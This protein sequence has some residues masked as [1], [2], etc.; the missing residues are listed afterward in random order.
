MTSTLFPFQTE[1][2]DKLRSFCKKAKRD[3][4]DDGEEELRGS[5]LI[6][7]IIVATQRDLQAK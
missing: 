7:M 1:A 6:A 2:L 4:K 3:Y 5:F